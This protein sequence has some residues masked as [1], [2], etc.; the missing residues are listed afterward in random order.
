MKELGL[1]L[2]EERGKMRGKNI[3]RYTRETLPR[4]RTNWYRLDKMSEEEI[5]KGAQDPDTPRWTKKCLRQQLGLCLE[6]SNCP[7]VLGSRY[8]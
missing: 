2:Q 5:E 3:V 1:F 8:C 6:K 4:G 7:H